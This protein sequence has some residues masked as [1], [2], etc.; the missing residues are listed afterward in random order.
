MGVIRY[1]CTL[2]TVSSVS[3]VDCVLACNWWAPCPE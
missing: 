2:E 1:F 3:A